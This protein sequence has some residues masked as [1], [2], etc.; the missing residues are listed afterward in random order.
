MKKFPLLVTAAVIRKGQK[1]LLAQRNFDDINGA[2]KWE[3]PGGKVDFGEHPEDCIRREIKEELN[4]EIAIDSFLGLS[5]HIYRSPGK[6]AH[7]ILLCYLC[8]YVAG[9]LKCLDAADAKWIDPSE[10]SSF[11]LA[12]ADKPLLPIL[13]KKIS[14]LP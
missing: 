8:D 9:E 7:V 10:V 5:S 6:E 1:I 11:D 2:G 13:S 4:I 14:S 12:D 3:F